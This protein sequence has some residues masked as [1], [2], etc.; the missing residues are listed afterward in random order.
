MM[1]GFPIFVTLA[2]RK[3]LVVGGGEPAARKIRLLRRAG[4][5]VTVLAPRLDAE[6]EEAVRADALAWRRERFEPHA[7]AELLREAALVFAATGEAEADAAVSRAAQ[8]AGRP[9]NAVDRPE[10]STF[11]MP[12]IVDRS[13]VVVAI[14]SGGAAPVLARRLRADLESRLPSG[15]GRLARLAGSFRSAVK[16]QIVEPEA[17]RRFW[18]RVLEGPVAEAALAGCE[19]EA[20]ER[21][22]GLVNRSAGAP[23]AEGRVHIVGAGP[24]DPDLLTL[25]AFRLLQEAD[26]IVHDRLIGPEILDLARRDAERIY[27]GKAK[28]RHSRPQDEINALLVR[29]ARA[30]RT[31]VRLKGGDPFIFGRGG[32]ELAALEAAGVKAEVV[33]GITAAAGCAAAAGIA[34]TH[35]DHA[36]GVTFVTGHGRDGEPD[37]D[38]AALARSRHTLVIYMGTSSAAATARRLIQHGMAATTPVAAIEN[39]TR[40][41]QRVVRGELGGLGALVAEHG[42]SGPT[43]IVFDAVASAPA[44]G[45]PRSTAAQGAAAAGA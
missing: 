14:S 5:R 2:G 42:I 8:A 11:T 34:L 22:I 29:L 32:E 40:A 19:S 45:A 3:A 15:L 13:P 25:R 33:P 7:A 44:A 4:A 17:R 23:P 37:C 24:G 6:L 30:G 36:S 28:A 27:V 31:V 12:A 18:E 1:S 21:M 10:L 38:W 9:V 16:A 20:R 43:V 35:R 39:G 41:E 26:V